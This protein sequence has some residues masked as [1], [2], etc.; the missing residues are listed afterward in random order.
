MTSVPDPTRALVGG[1]RVSTDAQADRYGPERQ[2]QDIEH[3]AQREGL[4]VIRWVEESISGANHDRAA[5]N[6]Y[7]TLARTHPGLNFMFS[8]PNRVGRHVEVIVGIARRI[9]QLGGTVWIAGLGNLRDSRNWKYFLRDA[10]EAESDYQNIVHQM[11]TGKRS[12]AASGRWPHGAVPWGYVLQRDH[13]GRSTLPALDP[14]TAPAVRRVFELSESQGQTKVLYV[15]REEGW[16]APTVAGW[17]IRTVSNILNN[18]RYTG[19]ALFQGIT[20]DFDPI[21]ERDQWE[22]VQARRSS[23]KRESGPRD[24]S[25]LWAGHA[26]CSCCGSA[27]GRDG[28]VTAS[29]SYIYYRCWKARKTATLREGRELCPN[30]RGW[31]TKEA[32]AAWWAW[33]ADQITDPATLQ[34]VLP[35]PP[36]QEVHIPPARLAELE[37]AIARAWEPFAAGKVTQAVAERLAAPYNVELERLKAEYAPAP[38]PEPMDYAELAADFGTAM[39]GA[40]SLEERRELLALLNVRLYVGPDGPERLTLESL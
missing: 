7:Y 37:A 40:Q 2:K 16:P 22:R 1:I 5:E 12:K 23:R 18:E 20:L 19:R 31:S 29:G 34:G 33:V 9:H 30:S 21:I 3:E 26:R 38:E 10:A 35:P 36:P 14:E 15:M 11:V 13:K 6:E 25:L 4:H 17:T 8:H 39:Q 32:D 28:T 27:V 24:T